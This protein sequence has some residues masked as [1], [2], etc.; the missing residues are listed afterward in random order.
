MDSRL[1]AAGLSRAQVQAVWIKQADAGPKEGFPGYAR[2][3]QR[4][5]ERIVVLLHDRFPNVKLVYL[6]SRTY[7]GYATTR[8]N[9]EPYAYES[10]F[11]VKWLIEQQIK[12]EAALNCDPKKGAV[13]AA[14]AELGA[15][16]VGQRQNEAGR[17]LQL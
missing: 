4:E 12:G 15:V 13:K 7:G 9:P 8:L 10:G 14:V 6:S 11:A 5:L 17:R 2:K 1:A 16:P 3:L